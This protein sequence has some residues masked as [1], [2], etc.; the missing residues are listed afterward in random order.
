MEHRPG[1]AFTPGELPPLV[2]LI[3]PC[4][5]CSTLTIS[6]AQITGHANILGRKR[7]WAAGT[8]AQPE[9]L[10]RVR[11]PLEEEWSKNV[12]DSSPC[13]PFVRG[14]RREIK[15]G[16]GDTGIDKL[17]IMDLQ[18]YRILQEYIKSLGK[19]LNPELFMEFNT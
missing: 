16:I 7:R 14:T 6:P 2:V 3:H 11:S 13:L 12:E 9:N 18:A 17:L 19:Q 5:S 8:A 1:R 15:V 10:F 4:A